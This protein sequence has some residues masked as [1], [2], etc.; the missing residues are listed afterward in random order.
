M[1]VC[2]LNLQIIPFYDDYQNKNYPK[3]RLSS[4]KLNVETGRYQ[5]VDISQRI[6]TLCDNNEIED[7]IHFILLCPSY[8]ALRTLY[9]KPY[10]YRRPS[11]FKMIQ[12]FSSNNV[13]ILRN[14]GRFLIHATAK[15]KELLN[16]WII[17]YV[18]YTRH[19]WCMW[20]FSIFCFVKYVCY[21]CTHEFCVLILLDM[22]N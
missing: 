18:C 12:L 6:C 14:L 3:Y 7:E 2:W 17:T 21:L 20:V 22:A 15:I 9:I 19:F 8:S 10:F 5:G 13:K 16:A 11:V 4:H 1:C